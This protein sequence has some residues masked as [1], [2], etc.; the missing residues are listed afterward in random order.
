MAHDLKTGQPIFHGAT[1]VGLRNVGS[2][3][4][5]GHPY[6][7]GSTLHAGQEKKVP[8]PYVT[9]K[10]TIIASGSSFG[11]GLRVHF[12]PT[13]SGTD[14]SNGASGPVV[15][16]NHFI[17]LDSHE[18]S[19]EFDVRCKEIYLSTPDGTA[20]GYKVYAS[21]TT[22]PTQSMYALTGSGLTTGVPDGE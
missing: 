22:I 5:S 21:L 2:Y 10:I 1:S 9:K 14:S 8:F 16:S 6:V 19:L 13:G 20:A 7:T 15:S 3:Q 12:N 18:D 11:Q 17:N 4:I